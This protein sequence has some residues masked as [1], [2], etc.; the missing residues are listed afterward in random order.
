MYRTILVPVDGSPAATAGLDEAIRI[1]RHIGARLHLMNIVDDTAFPDTD[2]S[3]AAHAAALELQNVFREGGEKVLRQAQARAEA[4][5]VIAA[6]ALVRSEAH[7]LQSLVAAQA[8][9]SGA[10]LIVLGTHGHRGLSRVFMSNDA[11]HLLNVVRVPVLLV[12]S[13]DLG[14][15]LSVVEI[16][17]TDSM[18]P[19]SP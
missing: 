10:D 8:E 11:G 5:G 15:D 4:A 12:R 9:H 7:D 14:P 3:E 16:S 13:T 2:S 19:T 18:F 1:A 17:A 6:S